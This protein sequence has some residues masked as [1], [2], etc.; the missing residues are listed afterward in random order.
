MHI[1]SSELCLGQ[2]QITRQMLSFWDE[3]RDI[4]IKIW[5]SYG[6]NI[7]IYITVSIMNH[8]TCTRVHEKVVKLLQL[9]LNLLSI[10]HKV[11]CLNNF[12]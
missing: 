9:T 4:D 10:L 12:L 11:T 5:G 6:T 3:I 2:K 8:T 1:R 7:Y